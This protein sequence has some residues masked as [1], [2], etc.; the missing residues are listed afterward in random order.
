MCIRDRYWIE[1][2]ST[3]ILAAKRLKF[4]GNAFVYNTV[5]FG[6]GEGPIFSNAVSYTHLLK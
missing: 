5:K 2:V 1:L 3:E 6:S 4:S